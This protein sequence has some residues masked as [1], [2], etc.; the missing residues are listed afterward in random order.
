VDDKATDYSND[1]HPKGELNGVKLSKNDDC[2][3]LFKKKVIARGLRGI[4]SL[5]RTFM[6]FDENKS[7]K[8]KRK[9]FHKFLDDYRFDIPTDIEN[10]LFDTFDKN[11]SG[12]IDYD[13]FIHALVG[14]MNDFRTQIVESVFAKLD[15][16][17]TGSVPYDVIRES[18]NVDKH[19]EVLSGKRTKEE[20]LSRFIDFFE[21]HFNLLNQ[22]KKK[23]SATLDDFIEFY[24][25]I[26]IFIDND[27]YFENMMARIWGLGNTENYGKVIR[28]VKYVSPY[29]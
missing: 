4:M 11:K 22:N 6:L 25:F 28:F 20:V 5:R 21:Y 13:E 18:Y 23:D 15:K 29:I 16:E 3:S 19:P 17:K 8:L 7:N 24:S 1:L 27:K 26:S 10:K 9:E 2:L 14:K 12:N